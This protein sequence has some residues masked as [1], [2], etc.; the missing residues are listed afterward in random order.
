ME[1]AREVLVAARNH[2]DT[3]HGGR[4]RRGQGRNQVRETA[5][6]IRNL[7]IRAVQRGR[8]RDDGR[9][10]VVLLTETAGGPTQALAVDLNVRTHLAQRLGE[11]ETVL[12]HGL[13][14]DR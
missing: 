11:T 1:L 12:V 2:V 6:Q 9:V 14:H 8:T 3:R 10:V 7:N 13:V 5:A 4:A